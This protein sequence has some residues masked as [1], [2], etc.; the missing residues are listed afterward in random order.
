MLLVRSKTH[1]DTL[2][3]GSGAEVLA[4]CG[5]LAFIVAG[6]LANEADSRQVLRQICTLLATD[7]GFV[8]AVR[9]CEIQ[10]P[11]TFGPPATA[12]AAAYFAGEIC[13]HWLQPCFERLIA[14]MQ[15]VEWHG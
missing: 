10:L 7:G 2:G 12:E 9:S 3:C 15:L 11:A 5:P 14:C 13:Q 6:V 4:S 1:T 8:P